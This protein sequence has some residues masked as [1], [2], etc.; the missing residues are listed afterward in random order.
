MKFIKR[1]RDSG[2]SGNR[3][4][5]LKQHVID[6]LLGNAEDYV[7]MRDWLRTDLEKT[8]PAFAT[9]LATEDVKIMED[10]INQRLRQIVEVAQSLESRKDLPRYKYVRGSRWGR[11]A[12]DAGFSLS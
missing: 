2:E 3:V 10:R 6:A 11:G 4:V 1:V 12:E 5:R 9:L 7:Y 8:K